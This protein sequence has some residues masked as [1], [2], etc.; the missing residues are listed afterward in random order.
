HTGLPVH[1]SEDPLSAVALGTGVVLSELDFLRKVAATE[2]P[3]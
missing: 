1:L 2:R 3:Y